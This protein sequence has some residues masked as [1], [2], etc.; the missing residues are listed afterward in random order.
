MERDIIEV[1]KI[2]IIIERYPLPP[3][4]GGAI[5]TLVSQ[6]LDENEKVHL[7]DFVV[8]SCYDKGAEIQSKSYRYTKFFYIKTNSIKYKVV[9]ALSYFCNHFLHMTIGNGFA[10]TVGKKMSNQSF[11]K[12][13]VEGNPRLIYGLIGYNKCS[14]ILHLH[15]DYLNKSNASSLKL[16]SMYEYVFTISDFLRKRIQ[17]VNPNYQKVYTVNNGIKLEPFQAIDQNVISSIKKSYHLNNGK[18]TILYSGRIVQEKGCL[19]VIQAFISSE[20]LMKNANLVIAGG[21]VYGEKGHSEYLS[22]I[23]KIIR[24]KANIRLTGYIPYQ[25]MPKLYM[26]A[27]IGIIPTMCEEAFGLCAIENMAAGNALIV[28]DS[29]ALPDLITCDNGEECG[30]VVNRD[31]A[32]VENLKFAMEKL[33]KDGTAR[34]DMGNLGKQNA[35][36]YTKTNYCR[37]FFEM[38]NVTRSK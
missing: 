6:Y 25:E 4:K 18:V 12:I 28:S 29:G 38:L 35:G 21:V 14:Y 19:E 20:Y 15:N 7:H 24:N 9:T 2:G 26:I 1:M 27:D 31:N 3:T 34:N 23:Q 11:D 8:Y 37:R 10:R 5:Q 36:K 33:V 16:L 32:Y 22:Q 17:E 13:I 30:I